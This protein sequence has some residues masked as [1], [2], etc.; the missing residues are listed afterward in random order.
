MIRR[1]S[2]SRKESDYAR[3]DKPELGI[4]LYD[5]FIITSAYYCY[6]IQEKLVINDCQSL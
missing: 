5:M 6:I 4:C 2:P 3:A 1:K